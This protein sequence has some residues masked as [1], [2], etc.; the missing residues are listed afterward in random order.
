[1]TMGHDAEKVL[2][3]FGLMNGRVR[4]RDLSGRDRPSSDAVLLAAAANARRCDQVL[5]AGCGSGAISLCVAARQSGCEFTGVD[6]HAEAVSD[7]RANAELNGWQERIRPICGDLA[8]LRGL[9]FDLVLSNP[10]FHDKH[11]TRCPDDG[12]AL[13]RFGTMDLSAWI[14]HCLRLC[15][16]RGH[17]VVILRADQLVTAVE[18]FADQAGDLRV[19]A[20]FSHAGQMA[21]RVLI[22]AR[23]AVRTQS[24]ILPGL[25]LH[26]AD[27]SWTEDAQRILRDGA[28]IDWESGRLA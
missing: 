12:R 22:R 5:D 20:I 24:S 28:A 1:M 26:G 21:N 16:P 23:K 25:V 8:A 17:V 3:T 15:R 19:L 2:T 14:G 6:V 9:A 7:L 27:G 18:A 4:L 13:A 10:P 11:S